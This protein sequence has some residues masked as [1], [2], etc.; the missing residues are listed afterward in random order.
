MVFVSA[1]NGTSPNKSKS[2]TTDPGE[3]G[4]VEVFRDNFERPGFLDP[5]KWNAVNHSSTVNEELEFYTPDDVIV[6][7]IDYTLEKQNSKTHDL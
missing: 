4:M 2:T 6:Q 5:A 1:V 3:G 7:G